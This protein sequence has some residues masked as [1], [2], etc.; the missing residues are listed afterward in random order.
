MYLMPEAGHYGRNM[1]RILTRLIKFAVVY[2][3]K[4]IKSEYELAS[5]HASTA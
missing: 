3:N 1:Q 5:C 2:G 4:R